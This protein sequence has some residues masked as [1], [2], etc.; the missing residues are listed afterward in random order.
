MSRRL[1]KAAQ[2]TKLLQSRTTQLSGQI[3]WSGDVVMSDEP[4]FSLCDDSR[5]M[6]VQRGVS[7]EKT[8]EARKILPNPSCV[9]ELLE[10]VPRVP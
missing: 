9:G 1:F 4:W 6:W 10:Q 3:N 7:K 2:V 5:R 8:F